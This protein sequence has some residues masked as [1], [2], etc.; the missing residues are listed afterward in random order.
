MNYNLNE[1]EMQ[2]SLSNSCNFVMIPS[3]L[4]GFQNTK[5][6]TGT[7]SSGRTVF[8]MRGN[9][10]IIEEDRI[11]PNCGFYMHINLNKET[12]L[13]HLCFGSNL[14]CVSFSQSQLYC[15]NCNI[16][17]MQSIPFKAN[18]H[19]ITKELHQYVIDLL[20]IGSYTNKQIAEITGL[21][22]NTIKDIDL[23]RLKKKYTINNQL[24]QP[25]KQ[26][27]YLGI[28]EF[29]LHNGYQYAT[30]IID[31]ETGH[32]LWIEKGKDKQI[33]FDFIKHVGFEWMKNVKA[34]ACDMNAGFYNAFK[35]K[36]PHIKVVFDYFHVMKNFNEHVVD[37]IYRDE[38]LRLISE[39]KYK[40][41]KSLGTSKFILYSSRETLKKKD[42]LGKKNK[43][44]Q[45]ESKIFKMEEIR[46]KT[47]YEERYNELIKENEL[48]LVVDIIKEK[49]K[50]L[51]TLTSKEE[52]KKEIKEIINICET[53]GNEHLLWLKRFL[54]FRIDGIISHAEYNIS[55]GKI[56]G[57]NNKIET[58]EKVV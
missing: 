52:M 42:E 36:C 37:K 3:F 26:A 25:E 38:K 13:R 9:L 24:I 14:S 12:T 20:T 23:E 53:N 8:N 17:K 32:I 55:S 22:K 4:N 15:E 41:A 46:R 35:E 18:N 45:K 10:D 16:S 43:L 2:L 39:K 5:T 57:I 44:Y 51:Y 30:H 6:I 7:T 58:F 21:G 49:L 27:R 28:D 40:E 56:E 48:L 29:K 33:V 34:V 31:L 11:C 47:G 1:T 50:T 54:L 19:R